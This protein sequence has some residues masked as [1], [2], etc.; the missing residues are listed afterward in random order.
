VRLEWRN[1]KGVNFCIEQAPDSDDVWIWRFELN[2]EVKTGKT[3]TKLRLLAIRRIQLVI[4]RTLKQ[5][6]ALDG[7]EAEL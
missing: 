3:V 5:R 1:H 2:G 7:G 6:S 4:N